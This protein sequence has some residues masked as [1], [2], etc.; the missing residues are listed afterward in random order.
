MNKKPTFTGILRNALNKDY[1]SDQAAAD[2]GK[3]MNE[4]TQM[5][6]RGETDSPRF[7]EL[8]SIIPI[9]E[10]LVKAK[11]DGHPILITPIG[12]ATSFSSNRRT[13]TAP[14]TSSGTAAAMGIRKIKKKI[15]E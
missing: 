14:W 11:L 6:L 3:L 8:E 2:L 1:T 15:N 9:Q 12:T 5:Q 7:V 13:S 4:A 10:K